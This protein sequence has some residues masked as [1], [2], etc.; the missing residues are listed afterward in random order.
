MALDAT[1][2]GNLIYT[3]S[4]G[5]EDASRAG[6]YSFSTAQ[7]GDVAQVF[8]P[9]KG[10]IYANGGAVY[11]DGIFY[12]LQHT[13]NTGKIQ[14][15]T[16]TA[17]DADTWTVL[18]QTSVPL[19]LSATDLTW[20]PVDGKVY[21]TF[22]N[23]TG[24]GYIFGTLSLTDGVVEEI[25]PLTLTDALGPMA[26]VGLASN[27][28]GDIFGIGADGAL[29]LFDRNT[30]EC[31]FV[32]ATGFAPERWNQSA[33]VDFT[34]G[35]LYWAACNASTSALF[36]IDTQTGQATL[37]RSF[38]D[39]EEFVGLYSES[40][41]GGIDGPMPP[42]GLGLSLVDDALTGTLQ[43]TMPSTTIVGTPLDALLSY[44]ATDNG[45]ALMAGEAQAG[46]QVS[47]QVTL[48]EGLHR[49]AVYASTASASGAVAR[50]T[51]YA[52]RDI[53]SAA[54]E[55]TATMTDNKVDI[56][57]TPVTTGQHGGY[58]DASAITYTVVRSPG[59]VTVAD[60][61]T[62]TQCSDTNLPVTL[63]D[64]IYN[65][66]ASYSG[67]TSEAASSTPLTMGQGF[68]P[69]AIL[70][71]TKEEQF[72]YFTVVDANDDGKT[73]TWSINGTQCPYHRD[74]ASDDW[75]MSPV[76][77]LKGG[78][79][80][81]ITMQ[82]RTG[83]KS[84]KEKYELMAGCAPE[85]SS[86][87]IPVI[88]NASIASTDR[89]PV[90]VTF[91][92]QTD[93]S[94]SF[95]LHCISPKYQYGLYIYSLEISAPVAP[96]APAAPTQ[97]AATAGS[98][99][100][101]TAQIT[102]TAPVLT[103]VGN[104]LSQLT[105]AELT[106][107]TTGAVACIVYDP[108]PG[109]EVTLTDPSAAN[110]VNE[111]SVAFYNAHGKGYTA[112]TS[113]YVGEDLP[114]PVQNLTLQWLTSGQAKLTWEAPTLGKNGGYINPDNLRYRVA[115][116]STGGDIA[117]GIQGCE[118]IFTPDDADSQHVEQYTVYASN[119]AGQSTGC[120]SNG[121]VFGP[122]YP[123]PFVESF[124]GG[125]TST[126]PWSTVTES[127]YP[128]WSATT[129]GLYD[130]DDPSVDGD[131]GYMKYSSKGIITLYSPV[132]D[133]ASLTNPVLKFWCR[134]FD[135]GA[136]TV[137]LE[138]KASTDRG[139]T[140]QS[141]AD[142]NIDQTPWQQQRIDLQPLAG[143]TSLQIA[144]RAS[145]TE[146][147]DLCL[148]AIRITEDADHDLAITA[149]TG[150]QR[151]DAGAT[152]LYRVKVLN[153]GKLTASG[154][155][156]HLTGGGR[157]LGSAQ[158]PAIE[159]SQSEVIDIETRIPIDFTDFTLMAAV[160]YTADQLAA[161]DEASIE[162]EV[163]TP[164]LPAISDLAAQT[165]PQG[166][167][168]QWSLP[169]QQ[170]NPSAI[171]DGFEDLTPWDYGGV[172]ASSPMGALGQYRIYD[173]DG[174]PTV[175]VSSWSLH[176]NAY[177]PMAFQVGQTSQ[178]YPAVDLTSYGVNA[179]T[180]TNSLIAWGAD[181]GASADWLILPRL[182]TGETT[183]SF[184]AH[185][186][187]MGWGTGPAEAFD[188]LYST[189]Q[190]EIADFILWVEDVAIPNGFDSD[191]EHGF[192]FYEYTLP[193]EA[194]FV[195]IR[196]K[197]S[198]G[199]NKAVVID[200]LTFTSA[201]LPVE[202]LAI[203]GYNVYRDGALIGQTSELQFVDT[204]ATAAHTYFVTTRYHLGES[205]MS[206][207]VQIT[208]SGINNIDGDSGQSRYFNLQGIEISHPRQGEVYIE[209][210]PGGKA[211]KVIYAQP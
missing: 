19:T 183:I 102:A 65:V 152:G 124:A 156:I 191:P 89:T 174:K 10:N 40:T 201:S 60:Q 30:G 163:K 134:A 1:L 54:S 158:G 100:A 12:A 21:G 80:Y 138:I 20:C 27:S 95:G 101:L 166:V 150:P 42:T 56:A 2:F 34:T 140:W 146:Y 44:S 29:Y 79:L 108:L 55:V 36:S 175:A 77:A 84:L 87:T 63:G 204:Q 92:P 111:Y 43:F 33:C 167:K 49:I 126:A 61:I 136:G 176:P 184:W 11:A 70:D 66:Y 24:S 98:D 162:V 141:L 5:D 197:L 122:A 35:T 45:E 57:W 26:M 211:R 181:Q 97:L 69:P 76:F 118:Y 64:Y 9:D 173:A 88:E 99:G 206:N 46:S 188:I 50:I 159:P 15:N 205:P 202:P 148:D 116:T 17:Y 90:S 208:F 200:D 180:G 198:T 142:F 194:K 109:A 147:Q 51:L 193:H 37:V 114:N 119:I 91:Q 103:A 155:S 83:H 185:A 169:A 115:N 4:W 7:G 165:D 28:A 187:A 153:D 199:S 190:P 154:Y 6:I 113:V 8:R 53:P 112:T 160:D 3:R 73:W 32:G 117:T 189:T 130:T 107:L 16:L 82:L 41:A 209:I 23:T 203:E 13:P 196:V 207:Q 85:V 161:N 121:I 128:L 72:K 106:N 93:G 139:S 18:S 171:T 81:T 110:G 168:L 151:M 133:I 182:F 132:V 96:E 137:T 105:K 75:L 192:K 170:R 47:R 186:A 125:K 104:P 71:L 145:A 179:R 172:S 127:G 164:R 31:T 195:A 14:T 177:A 67:K 143:S 52:G 94:Y 129:K 144:F 131:L 120:N 178:P 157:I 58:V 39:D 123:T 48:A 210:T 86:M 22:L 68:T 25:A 62:A 135:E 74:N 149:L 59:N 78:Y 38:A